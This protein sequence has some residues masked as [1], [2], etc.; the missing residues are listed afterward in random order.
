MP[1]LDR[2]AMKLAMRGRFVSILRALEEIIN[3]G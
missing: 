2:T 3:K 1:E